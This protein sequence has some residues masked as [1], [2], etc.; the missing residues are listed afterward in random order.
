MSQKKYSHVLNY[1]K[2]P[3]L[4]SIFTSDNDLKNVNQSSL[5]R[6]ANNYLESHFHVTQVK[7]SEKEM[8]TL[9]NGFIDVCS[10][11]YGVENC[12]REQV[13][14]YLAL[15]I[16][17]FLADEHISQDVHPL[18]HEYKMRQS[19]R[20]AKHE[21]INHVIKHGKLPLIFKNWF[22]ILDSKQM[23]DSEKVSR[24]MSMAKE[25]KALVG[26]LEDA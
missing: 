26:G 7:M 8:N 17:L 14:N 4:S 24:M 13:K 11:K 22:N 25:A 15:K 9:A 6:L 18:V 16:F 1:D 3:N 5:G 21:S 20:G 10:Q 2:Y 23:T 19:D 12:D